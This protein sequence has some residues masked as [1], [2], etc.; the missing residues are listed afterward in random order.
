MRTL[1]SAPLPSLQITYSATTEALSNPRLFPSAFRTIPSTEQQVAVM[2][3]LLRWFRWNW[4]IVLASEDDYGQQNLQLLRSQAS[5]A[6]IAFQESIPVQ[7]GQRDAG[8]G[9]A[10]IREVV[11]K[12]ARST[13]RVVLV[14]SLELPLLAFFP[15]VLRQNVSGLVWIGAEA[16][17]SDPS[18]HSIANLSSVG[19]IFGVAARNVPI[20]GLNDFRVRAPS[21][22]AGAAPAQALGKT[23]NQDCDRCLAAAQAHDRSLRGTGHRIDFNVYSAV[24]VVA[25]ALHRLLRCDRSGCHKQPIRPWQ[26]RAHGDRQ[27]AV[28]VAG[29]EG[30]AHCPG[31]VPRLQR[32]MGQACFGQGV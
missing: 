25:H 31:S 26:V 6:C 16:W 10:R 12:I 3:R 11:G 4:V 14:F 8:N 22:P 7:Q 32:R 19:T 28:P 23:C 30:A 5:W 2:L 27:T 24:Y 21:G 1:R 13:A 20:P 29:R 18:V 17:A 15:E 9:E